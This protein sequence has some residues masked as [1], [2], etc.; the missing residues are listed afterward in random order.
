MG[1]FLWVLLIVGILVAAGAMFFRKDF[2]MAVM[3]AL[4]AILL[5]PGAAIVF[6]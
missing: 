3:L 4:I 5:G 2:V 6:R 1:T